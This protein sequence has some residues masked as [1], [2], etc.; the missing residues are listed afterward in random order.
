MATKPTKQGSDMKFSLV[1]A[2]LGREREVAEFIAALQLQTYRDFELI[3]VDQ[4][5]D[6][7]ID[8]VLRTVPHTFPVR[9]K[10]VSFR[11][12]ARARTSGIHFAAGDVVAFPDDDC[13]YAEDVLGKVAHEFAIQPRLGILCA[14]SYEF[15]GEHFSVGVNAA[16]P[17]YF[18]RFS[19]M[20]VEFTHFFRLANIARDEFYMDVDFGIGSKYFGA[21]GFELLYRLLRAGAKAFYTPHIRVFHANKDSINL[22][23]ERIAKHSAGVGAYIRKFTNQG[24]LAMAIFILRKMLVAPPV[25]IALAALRCDFK[26]LNY[27]FHSLLGVWRGFLAYQG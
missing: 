21:E 4:N 1:M 18:S 23:H 6:D 19:M 25:K 8:R 27:A 5:A 11:G 17:R 10:K 22:G 9:H 24:D 15:N 20:G 14:G 16:E 12:N 13:I 2:T 26:R 3:I 7:R